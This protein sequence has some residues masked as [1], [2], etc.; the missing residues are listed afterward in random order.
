MLHKMKLYSQPFEMIKNGSKNVE[1]RLNDE[2][3]QTLSIGDIIEF[4]EID[5]LNNKIRVKV[6]ALY[7]YPD[8]FQL[9]KDFDKSSIGYKSDEI[10]DPNDMY[11]YY[12]KENIETYGALAIGLQLQN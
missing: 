9:Y 12:S 6:T 5:N 4:S 7:K 11:N 1:I 10:A 8:F 3:R 2:K